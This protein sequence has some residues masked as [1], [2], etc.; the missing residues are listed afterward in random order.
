MTVCTFSGPGASLEP[1]GSP[2]PATGHEDGAGRAGCAITADGSY[3]A[4]LALAGDSLFPERWTLDGPEPYAVPLP[5]NQPEEPGTEVQPLSD[6]RVLIHRLVDGRHAFSLLYPTGPGTGELPLGTVECPEEGTRLRLLPP[7]PGGERAYALAVGRRSTAVWLV[8]GGGFGPEHLAEVPGRCSGGVWLDRAGRLLAL[9]RETGGRTKAVVV[10][11]GR[12]GEM[13]PLLQIA[14]G[15]D[16]RV[17]LADPDSGLLLVRSDA[18]SPGRPRLG[19]GVLGSTLPVRFPE[20]LRTTDCAVTPFAIQPGQMLTPE[21]CAVA[22]RVDGALGSWVGVWRPAERRVHHL[23]APEGWLT[24]SGLWTA[25]GVLRLPYAT[26]AVPCGVARLPAPG[27]P[28]RPEGL[29]LRPSTGPGAA[30]PGLPVALG[31]FTIPGALP[32]PGGSRAATG[33]P[34]ATGEPPSAPDGPPAPFGPDSPS[35]P[36][37]VPLQQAPLGGLVTK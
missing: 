20:C 2:S 19:W 34:A 29:G 27:R 7:A 35:A 13:S 30:V 36:R 31:P 26:R 9:D 16:D 17:L 25:D 23:P 12:G 21:S 33:T 5:G 8:A 11:L 10:D 4:R 18:P 28:E 14:D 24:G 15:S 32:A 22:L 37:P 6:G 1:G 3:A